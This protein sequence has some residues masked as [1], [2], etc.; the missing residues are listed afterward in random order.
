MLK[1]VLKGVDLKDKRLT[2]NPRIWAMY[3]CWCIANK[4][5]YDA[6]TY[7]DWF[8]LYVIKH[9]SPSRMGMTWKRIDEW[10]RIN[11]DFKMS[12]DMRPLPGIIGPYAIGPLNPLWIKLRHFIG[13]GSGRY[14]H[15]CEFT[16]KERGALY[17]GKDGAF[18]N[19]L[20]AE[21]I[22]NISSDDT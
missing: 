6:F 8:R 18:M 7:P 10:K 13:K 3:L 19:D 1:F 12:P 11:P 20:F 5:S 17:G 21:F 9:Y 4:M 15:R 22:G 2:R 14:S 16:D